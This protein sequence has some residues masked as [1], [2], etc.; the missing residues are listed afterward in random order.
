MSKIKLKKI[1]IVK[2]IFLSFLLFSVTGFAAAQKSH[3]VKSGESVAAIA[4]YYGV[5]QDDLRIENDLGR[6]EQL[7]IGQEIRIPT[8]FRGGG[9]G[10][11]IKQGDNLGKIAKKY[12][13]SIE[14]L[15]A[16]NK[17]GKNS[18]LEV[19][20]TLVIPPKEGSKITTAK[21]KKNPKLVVSGELIPGGVLHTVLSGQNIWMIARAYNVSKNQIAARNNISVKQPLKV[22]QKLKIPGAKKVVPVRVK[23]YRAG[24]IHFVRVY[25]S[26]Q[27]NLRLVNSKGRL[28][29]ASRTKLS[30]LSGTR[31]KR[32]KFKLFHPRLIYMIQRVSERYPGQTIE[33]ISGY[34]PPQKGHESRHAMGRAIDFRIPGVSNRELYEFCTEMENSGCGYYPNSVFIHMDARERSTTWTDYSRPGQKAIYKKTI[35]A[36]PSDTVPSDTVP[37]DAVDDKSDESEDI[38]DEPGDKIETPEPAL[39]NSENNLDE[40]EEPGDDS[41]TTEK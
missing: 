33:I 15:K 4:D 6:K 17:M 2:V 26:K 7:Q 16:E 37:S 21:P 27:L 36:V 22:G 9:K 13:I 39:D 24:P 23:G 41:E 34:R 40:P 3:V 18:F 31:D 30:K 28:I 12:K 8:T 14:K 38:I 32:S 35:G 19:G 29:P 1:I 5:S 10:H 20:R 25:N 11:V